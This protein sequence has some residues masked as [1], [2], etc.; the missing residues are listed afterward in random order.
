MNFEWEEIA[1]EFKKIHNAVMSIVKIYYKD[2]YKKIK[3][4]DRSISF[5][6]LLIYW[7]HLKLNLS[8]SVIG[9]IYSMELVVKNYFELIFNNPNF[10]FFTS[11]N[12]D[13]K[14]LKEKLPN[15]I[16]DSTNDLVS[17][18]YETFKSYDCEIEFKNLKSFVDSLLYFFTLNNNVKPFKEELKEN[19]KNIDDYNN[20]VDIFLHS[21]E[22]FKNARD[23]FAT[24]DRENLANITVG[25][26][27]LA[28]C[29]SEK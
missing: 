3:K 23:A 25:I 17:G 16:A 26:N 19:L 6:I 12:S 14:F 27:R 2:Y 22:I 11:K 7:I 24:F 5:I 21:L 10:K 1:K 28:K 18:I 9:S 8:Y 29:L 15:I 20:N 13:L 4:N